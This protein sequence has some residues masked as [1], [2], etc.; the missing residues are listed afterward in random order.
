MSGFCC[1]TTPYEIGRLA[2]QT[3]RRMLGKNNQTICSI[4]VKLKRIASICLVH[5]L[6]NAK[7]IKGVTDPLLMY[8]S[9]Y[10]PIQGKNKAIF[11]VWS[12]DVESHSHLS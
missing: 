3:T 1:H 9:V 8:D 11:L 10:H 2:W 5:F 6:V 4:R 7:T 12:N